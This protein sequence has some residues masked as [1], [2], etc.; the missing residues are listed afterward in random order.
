MIKN[1]SVLALLLGLLL[2][3]FAMQCFAEEEGEVIVHTHLYTVKEQSEEYV[4][5]DG[6][7]AKKTTYWYACEECGAS[8]ELDPLAVK[9]YYEGDEFG[10][11]T[12]SSKWTSLDG[13]HWRACT[14]NGCDE[15]TDLGEHT[16]DLTAF[17]YSD[18]LGH[19]HKCTVCGDHDDILP[20][21]TD[22]GAVATEDEPLLC[23]ECKFIIEPALNHKEHTPEEEWTFN[24]VAHWHEC[25]GC[26]GEK[27]KY[28]IHIDSD[29]DGACD[30][31][32]YPVPVD[33][34]PKPIR[35][36][37]FAFTMQLSKAQ[38]IYVIIATL[39]IIIFG[40]LIRMAI[41]KRKRNRW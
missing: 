38:V 13:N 16:F 9:A 2:S 23:N 29:R 6:N 8:A 25:I 20:H 11:H 28:Q 35:D 39:C 34:E 32:T 19:A 10:D 40:N 14:Q 21:V 5:D 24:D 12:F 37:L 17:G 22:D 36:Y 1:I 31:C 18:E 15:A 4:R 26:E 27:I 33:P 3:L 7:C 30:T 41:A